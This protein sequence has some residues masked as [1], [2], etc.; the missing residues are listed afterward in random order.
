[1]SMNIVAAQ[2][3]KMVNFIVLDSG[4][5]AEIVSS[6]VLQTAEYEAGQALGKL[7]KGHL[8]GAT[9]SSEF[10]VL[11]SGSGL[12][13]LGRHAGSETKYLVIDVEQSRAFEKL[14]DAD[15]LYAFQKL[16]RFARKYWEGLSMTYSEK[17]ISGTS[18]AVIFPFRY[19]ATPYR[20]VVERE[21]RKER[22]AKRGG[23]GKHLLMYKAGFEGGDSSTEEPEYTNFNRF[24][25]AVEEV[26]AKLNAAAD[27]A[28][29]SAPSLLSVTGLSGETGGNSMFRAYADWL[30]ALTRQQREFVLAPL[31]GAHR[32]EGAAGTGK[33]LSLL[34]KAVA[35]L[36]VAQE[37][38]RDSHIVFITHSE[39]TRNAIAETLAVVDADD[40]FSQ[41]SRASSRQSLKVCTL[42]QLC[43][44]VLHQSISETE[45]IDRDAMESKGLQRLYI[46]EAIEAAFKDELPSHE[47]FLSEGFLQFLRS[48]DS[49]QLAGMFQ[50]EISV[51]IKGRASEKFHVYKG[52]PALKYGLPVETEADKGFVFAVFDRYQQSLGISG[53][54]DTDDVVLSAIGQ[55]D[56]PIWRRRRVR[57]GYDALF[58]DETH[59]FNINELNLFHYFT[60]SEGAFQIV[61][62][63]DRSQAVGDHGWTT[64]D[65]A[66]SIAPDA[67]GDEAVRMGTVFRCAPEIVD[68]AFFIVSS[69]ATLFTN[70]ENP[71]VAASSGFTEL[72]ERKSRRPIYRCAQNEVALIE[73]AF[74]R[75]DALQREL[76]CKRGEVLIVA[77]DDDVVRKLVE[78]AEANA[79]PVRALARRGDAHAVEAAL[80][81]GQ[82]VIGHADYV[83]GLE[84][85]AVI[86]VGVDH[87]RVPPL[88]GQESESGKHFLSYSAH[89]RLYVAVTRAKYRVEVLGEKPRGMSR[90]MKPAVDQGL[91]EVD[92]A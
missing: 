10:S 2:E 17:I 59:L 34:L 53:Q 36:K 37:E 67:A 25:D 50:H 41:R 83:G 87:G 91:L 74:E 69:G 29:P 23:A 42:S 28:G 65:I 7:L 71:L 18:K 44:E 20:F 80:V 72:D 88:D 43:G 40:A 35:T 81:A 86:L 32:I 51:L 4:A 13:M 64:T 14:N 77:T 58:I 61:Y 52:V 76:G 15:A 75:A 49:W 70:F 68:L 8:D 1:M 66:S 62:S 27:A 6:R 47:R 60:K 90:V 82:Y 22:L 78:F 92:P 73:L 85:Q 55:L 11:V 12:Y 39:A 16:A 33:T 26:R 3:F 54:F 9:L 19:T 48:E 63:V 79:K 38:S 5:I 45:L 57:D 24:L 30:P 46:G 21:P 89:N 84:F 56:T 31:S